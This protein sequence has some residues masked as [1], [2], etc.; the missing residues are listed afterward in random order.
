MESE[1]KRIAA[2]LLRDAYMFS[3][4]VSNTTLSAIY[5]TLMRTALHIVLKTNGTVKG[6]GIDT[7]MWRHATQIIVHTRVLLS[8]KIISYEQT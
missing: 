1:R 3:V 7:S 6:M 2:P 4:L 5:A 8:T